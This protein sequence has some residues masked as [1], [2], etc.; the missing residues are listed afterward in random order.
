MA[1]TTQLKNKIEP[2][3]R[4]EY[5]QKQYPNAEIVQKQLDL[6]DPARLCLNLSARQSAQ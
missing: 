4:H 6:I 5:L 1:N 3:F 2:W